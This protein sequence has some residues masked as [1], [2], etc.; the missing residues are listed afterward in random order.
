MVNEAF[1]NGNRNRYNV[2]PGIQISENAVQAFQLFG[3]FS[4][5]ENA[6]LFIAV[7]SQVFN[8]HIKLPVK[9]RLCLGMEGQNVF[10]STIRKIRLAQFKNMAVS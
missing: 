3:A 8:Q 7:S 6:I 10:L 9:R 1:V 2:Q 4:E 5:N